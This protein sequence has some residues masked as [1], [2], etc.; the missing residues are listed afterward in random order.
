MSGY[1][2]IIEFKGIKYY[3]EEGRWHRMTP[4]RNDNVLAD[5]KTEKHLQISLPQENLL[6]VFKF[7]DFDQLLSF[8]E[9][10]LYFKNII[11]KYG[12]E[13]ARKKFAKLK[14]RPVFDLKL[15]GDNYVKIYPEY[16]FIEIPP[17]LYYF[18]LSEHLEQKWIRGIEESIPMFLT[19]S[20]YDLELSEPIEQRDVDTIICDLGQNYNGKKV[21]YH[22]K[23]PK[24]PQNLEQMA[25]A[26]FLFK[27]LFNCV[28]EYL[29]IRFLFNPKMIQLLLD[30]TT[31]L[32]LQIHS[33]QAKI[34][35]YESVTLKF[36]L[37][38]LVSK[39]FDVV[40]GGTNEFDVEDMDSLFKFLA[41][42]NKFSNISYRNLDS[43]FYNYFIEVCTFL[44]KCL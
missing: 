11:D 44:I 43:E 32:P 20:L 12:K 26:R 33:Q 14:F 31:N 28:F 21:L 10:S 2:K 23:L 15:E 5:N 16:K 36:I 42:G 6:D 9:T 4:I 29:E 40:F 39:Q 25:I 34:F 17:Q 3:L 35:S 24:F 8:Q 30:E 19:S 41:E 13:L 7:L 1:R 18:E 38:H 22:I 27:L 37:N